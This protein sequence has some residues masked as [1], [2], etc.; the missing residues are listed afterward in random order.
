MFAPSAHLLMLRNP[1]YADDALDAHLRVLLD[2]ANA[3]ALGEAD[4]D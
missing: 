2:W 1:S 3:R 4:D